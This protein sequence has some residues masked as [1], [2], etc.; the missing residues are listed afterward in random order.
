[1][2]R[3]RISI[4]QV[5]VIFLFFFLSSSYSSY[6]TLVEADFLA[7]GLK[8]EAPDV[9]DFLVGKHVFADF[10]SHLLSSMAFVEGDLIEKFPL[11]S[12]QAPGVD[13]APSILR[14]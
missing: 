12:F 14:C 11:P 5:L 3:K 1:M 2:M 7:C 4:L 9:G 13:P 8:F 10:E 6:N